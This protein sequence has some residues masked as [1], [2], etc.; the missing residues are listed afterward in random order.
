MKK[1]LVA[2]LATGLLILGS[3]GMAQALTMADVGSV[4]NLIGWETLPNSG[5]VTEID[6]INSVLG[7]NFTVADLAKTNTS[8]AGWAEVTD[9]VAGSNIYAFDFV[10]EAPVYFYVK[11]GEGSIFS[12]YVYQNIANLDWAVIDL[13]FLGGPGELVDIKNIGKL[14]HIG[15]VGGTP[16]P[17]PATMLLFGTGIAGLAGIARRKRS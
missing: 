13:N 8:A 16:V 4:D 5:D 14:S 12:H 10:S 6:W 7:S 9:G 17:E 11:V 1:T 2:T 15:E 3:V